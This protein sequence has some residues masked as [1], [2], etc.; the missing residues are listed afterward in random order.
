MS[1][2]HTTPALTDS[3]SRRQHLLEVY[4]SRVSPLLS[5][6]ALVYLAT[7]SIQ[8]IWYYPQATWFRYMNIF[9]NLLWVLFVIDLAFRFSV[10]PDKRHFFQ[11][12]IVDTITV[13]VPQFRAIRALRAFTGGGFISKKSGLISGGGLTSALLAA[14]IVV[15]VGSLM[16]LNAERSAANAEIKTAGDAVWWG[17]ETVTTVGYGDFVP[18][19]WNGR[20][21]AVLVMLVGISVLGVVTASL[22]AALVK[23]AHQGPDKVDEVLSELAE[24]KAMVA[25]LEAKQQGAS[26]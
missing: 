26:G 13:I 2:A 18:V 16:V 12:N 4:M 1:N 7:F 23:R 11:K 6:L 24:L 10:S 14:L 8:A 9:G 20:M 21:L 15:W 5:F 19:T 17:F 25:R 3:Q 22:S